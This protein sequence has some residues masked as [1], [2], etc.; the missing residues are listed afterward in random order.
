MYIAYVFICAYVSGSK[1][2]PSIVQRVKKKTQIETTQHKK[3]TLL[4]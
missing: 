3:T 1:L 2:K 4:K